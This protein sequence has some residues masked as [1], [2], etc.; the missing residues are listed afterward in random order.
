MARLSA[1]LFDTFVRSRPFAVVHFS[2]SWNRHDELMRQALEQRIPPDVR[3][4]IGFAELNTD[5]PESYEFCKKLNITN[6]P[7]LAFYRD[8]LMVRTVT[9][10]RQPAELVGYL[11]AL[12]DSAEQ[13]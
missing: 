11:A 3:D 7:F 5:L 4:R 1:P 6:L 12:V 2:A 13:A 9:G 10:L 8:G